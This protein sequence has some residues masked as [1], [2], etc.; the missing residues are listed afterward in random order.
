M[1]NVEWG[2]MGRRKALKEE[3]RIS[4]AEKE[5]IRTKRKKLYL[6]GGEGEGSQGWRGGEIPGMENGRDSRD[7]E[8]EGSQGWR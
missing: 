3:V 6:K 7:G 5:D 1:K 8:G 4:R 2:I